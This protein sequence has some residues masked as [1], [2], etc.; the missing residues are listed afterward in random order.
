MRAARASVKESQRVLKSLKELVE[1]LD[2]SNWTSYS[3]PGQSKA[4]A[5]SR[6]RALPRRYPVPGTSARRAEGRGQ[7]RAERI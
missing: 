2:T 3:V 4:V 7:S 6:G 5:V 1:A